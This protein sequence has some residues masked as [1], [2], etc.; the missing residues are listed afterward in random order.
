MIRNAELNNCFFRVKASTPFTGK[1]RL[2]S[3]LPAL[4]QAY[5]STP[6]DLRGRMALQ[7]GGA[8]TGHIP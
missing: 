6:K 7:R 5:Q 2:R 3:P 4:G 8:V 1:D